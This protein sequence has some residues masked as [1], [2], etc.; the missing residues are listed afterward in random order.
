MRIKTSF[1]KARSLDVSRKSAQTHMSVQT[2][3]VS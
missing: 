2:A 3:Q 1:W